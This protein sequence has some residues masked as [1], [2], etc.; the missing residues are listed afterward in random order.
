MLFRS[1]IWQ[2]LHDVYLSDAARQ[3]VKDWK[4]VKNALGHKPF[5]PDS[6]EYRAFMDKTM[7]KVA[8]LS[9]KYPSLELDE[10][11]VEMKGRLR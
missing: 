5:N 8:E 7:L 9:R 3:F 10:G 2:R 11:I 4:P 6:D 1:Y